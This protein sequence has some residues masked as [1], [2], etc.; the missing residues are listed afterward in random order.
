MLLTITL[1]AVLSFCLITRRILNKLIARSAAKF[2]HPK[3]R[4]ATASPK[5]FGI[6]HWQDVDF[7]SSDGLKL[8]GWFIP[9]ADASK[10]TIIFAHGIRGNR[11]SLLP[12]AAALVSQGYGAL[13]FDLRNHGASE[14]DI[15]TMSAQ[16]VF[17]VEG[18]IRFLKARSDVN[19]ANIGIIGHSLGAATAIRAA[20]RYTD[21][22]F[23]VAQAAFA[24]LCQSMHQA[25]RSLA[26]LSARHR[27]LNAALSPFVTLMIRYAETQVGEKA[28]SISPLRDL[29]KFST[30]CLF[31]HGLNDSTIDASNSEQLYAQA[32]GE[33][34]LLLLADTGHKSFSSKDYSAFMSSV[35][36][37][38][39]RHGEA[40]TLT[41]LP[42][43]AAPTLSQPTM[44][45]S[46]S[47]SKQVLAA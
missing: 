37:F 25:A 6:E 38:V 7:L 1:T 34:E 30:P 26:G 47:H 29:Q 5:D 16:E 12:Q 31:I 17:D 46:D 8:G 2:L 9:A 20:A 23:V 21:I 15:T 41:Y 14:G 22:K 28:R 19:P 24:D 11:A 18:A 42:E 32:K 43:I 4:L 35:V 44:S 27:L 13:L 45:Q 36:S 10:A 3:R 40:S 39:A 33:K